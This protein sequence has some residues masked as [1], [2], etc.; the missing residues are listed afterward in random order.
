MPLL[1]EGKKAL[2]AQ[3][4]ENVKGAKNAV[5]LSLEGIPVNE[6]NQVR[7]G[8]S[9]AQWTLEV[10][11]KRVFM[12]GMEGSFE[13]LTLEDASAAIAVLYSHNEED[14]HAPLKVINK[15]VKSWKKAKATYS[16]GYIG[17]WYDSVWEGQEYVSELAALPS[18]EEL[19]GKFLFMLNHPVSSFARVLQAI[20]DKDPAEAPAEETTSE[21]EAPAEAEAPVAEATETPAEEAAPEADAPAE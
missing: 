7:M 17:G 20:A 8:I 3:Y 12:K 14:Q 5:I 4:L 10:V 11:K 15:A 21:V 1:K 13:W 6:I 18:K 2:A 9:D 16:F 19:V